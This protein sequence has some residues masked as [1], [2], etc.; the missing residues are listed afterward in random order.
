MGFF[1][2]PF[3]CC[4]YQFGGFPKKHPVLAFLTY[5]WNFHPD[6]WGNVPI[7][8][9]RIFFKWVVKNH[10][11]E[12]PWDIRFHLSQLQT[13]N[14]RY[15]EKILRTHQQLDE[16]QIWPLLNS[17]SWN[18]TIDP[19]MRNRGGGWGFPKLHRKELD[20]WVENLVDLPSMK[21]DFWKKKSFKGSSWFFMVFFQ[22]KFVV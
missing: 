7:W 10:Q 13:K 1:R 16:S 6:P 20:E 11:L 15:N 8:R 5:F 21:G 17:C 2:S 14:W 12:K 19:E 22:C 9:L 3:G 18:I 4:W